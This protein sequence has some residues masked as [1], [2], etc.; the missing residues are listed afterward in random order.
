MVTLRDVAAMA[1]VHPQRCSRALHKSEVVQEQTLARVLAAARA[2]GYVPNR[3]AAS[4]RT[5]A[6][7]RPGC[8]RL[9]WPIRS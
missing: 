7:A 9:T 8:W 3:A 4:L 2:L 5:Q 6:P 1:D